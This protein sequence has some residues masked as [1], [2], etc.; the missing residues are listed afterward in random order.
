MRPESAS[1]MSRRVYSFYRAVTATYIISTLVVM[2]FY[3]SARWNSGGSDSHS[4]RRSNARVLKKS[5]FTIKLL[6]YLKVESGEELIGTLPTL[7]IKVLKVQYRDA[8]ALARAA[9]ARWPLR[10]R[11]TATPYGANA[12]RLGRT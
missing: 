8:R 4:N 10:L 6:W 9:M 7:P 2:A 1:A 5:C 3:H 12:R 11:S